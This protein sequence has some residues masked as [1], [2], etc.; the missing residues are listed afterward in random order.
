MSESLQRIKA[1]DTLS[2]RLDPGDRERSAM[3]AQ[4]WEEAEH[5][6]QHTEDN[7][8]F[9]ADPGPSLEILASP[10]AEDGMPLSDILQLYDRA[11]NQPGINPASGGHLGYIPGG[12]LYASALGDFIAAYTNR[13]AGVFFGNPGAVRM[14]NL[15]VRW[16][17]DLAGYPPEAA[18]AL[19]S[20]GSI[21]NLSCIVTARDAQGVKSADVARSVIYMTGQV[22]H[23]VDKAIHIAGLG[24]A[25]VRHVPMD[26]RFRMDPA[27]L[28]G[29][30][31]QDLAEGLKPFLVV[32][33]TGTTDTGAIDPVEEIAP[34]TQEYGLWLHVDAAYGGFF[35]L[36][37][38]GRARI[39]GL[40]HA[41]SIVMDPHKGLFLPYGSGVA[42][43]RNGQYL[44]NSHRYSANY[45]LDALQGAEE[46]S[47]ADLSPELTKHFRGMR[48]WLPLKLHGVAP[49]R[50][51]VEEKLWLA[52][53]FWEQLPN[54][55]HCERGPAPD[56]SVV[57]YR[58][59]PP[60][61]DPND[62]NQRLVSRLHAD[63][64]VFLSSTLVNGDHYL[65][66]ACLSFRTHL[67][68]IE[69]TLL[70]L[71]ENVEALLAERVGSES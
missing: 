26:A 21:A 55:P 23:C 59:C 3:N 34:I 46:A 42:L 43:V 33:S 9:R 70:M 32:A 56:L 53:Y 54:L 4:V 2:R 11:V 52:T 20:G 6:L 60:G 38:P 64:R 8:A 40:D 65:R 31:E 62:F 66:L 36:C 15:L 61:R 30:I 58:F 7:P 41:D 45:M 57:L 49:F 47:P 5:F 22:H 37:E 24:E 17:A 50:A 63:G 1:L 25:I 29:Q 19:L 10:P 18:G 12:G 28:R 44:A 71:R 39:K 16:C 14:E 69:K 51:C 68:T 35:L 67:E 13:Y 27:G 48:M